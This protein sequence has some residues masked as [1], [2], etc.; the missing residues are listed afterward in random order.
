MMSLL[1]QAQ[2]LQGWDYRM[3][4][5]LGVMLLMALVLFL[6]AIAVFVGHSRTRES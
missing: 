4:L 3:L 5:W 2:E 6:A 1:A